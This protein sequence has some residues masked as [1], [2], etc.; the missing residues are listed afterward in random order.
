MARTP[1][2]QFSV[3]SLLIVTTIV[4]MALGA[5]ALLEIPFANPAVQ[6][7]L[8]AYL[9]FFGVWTIIRGPTALRNFGEFQRRKRELAIQRAALAEEVRRKK[10]A[11]RDQRA[12]ERQDSTS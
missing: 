12:A 11:H 3:A 7:F 4:A 8:A 1:Q 10:V 6:A 2:I 9:I 5:A